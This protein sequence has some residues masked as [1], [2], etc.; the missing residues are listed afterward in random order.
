MRRKLA[1]GCPQSSDYGRAQTVIRATYIALQIFVTVGAALNAW[2]FWRNLDLGHFW[3]AI[4]SFVSLATCV[5][6][7][8]FNMRRMARFTRE[9][10]EI[11]KQ[12]DAEIMRL[13]VGVR[14][15]LYTRAQIQLDNCY[16]DGIC[17]DCARHTLRTDT[18]PMQCC[19]DECGSR[20]C[21]DDHGKW[22]RA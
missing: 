18:T 15:P 11:D 2:M 14:A 13:T 9:M 3:W 1:D 5:G 22:A 4:V 17:P 7:F 8:I 6:C 16:R 19:A 21:R 10:R 20:F 12:I